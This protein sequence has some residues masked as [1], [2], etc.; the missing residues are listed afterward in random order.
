MR[1]GRQESTETDQE[2][3]R[4]PEFK[5]NKKANPTALLS[6]IR[7]L[8]LKGNLF[9]LPFSRGDMMDLYFKKGT[10]LQDPK[11]LPSQLKDFYS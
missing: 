4:Q 1:L 9:P 3:E 2:R 7:R 11:I 6:W 5:S 8:I 10:E